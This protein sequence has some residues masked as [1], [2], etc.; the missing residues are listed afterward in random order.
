MKKIII[1][2]YKKYVTPDLLEITRKQ[3]L[4]EV[5]DTRFE[6]FT[7]EDKIQHQKNCVDLVNN[8][9]LLYEMNK[10]INDIKTHIFY[11]VNTTDKLLASRFSANGVE[12]LLERIKTS[13]EWKPEEEQ[14]FDKYSP[15]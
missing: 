4:G 10:Y 15:I 9:S 1:W 8:K 3:F 14:E 12:A 2:L 6:D 11:E 5:V 7:M 13:S